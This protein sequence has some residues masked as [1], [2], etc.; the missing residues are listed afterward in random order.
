MD[1]QMPMMKAKNSVA[2]IK[3]SPVASWVL[4]FG[5][6]KDKTYAEVKKDDLA[7]LTYLLQQGAFDDEKYEKTNARIKDYIMCG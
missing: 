1:S 6:Y 5:K 2:S 7:Y 4:K 3:T